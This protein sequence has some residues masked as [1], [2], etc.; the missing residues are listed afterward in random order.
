MIMILSFSE[1]ENCV[2]LVAAAISS[3][4]K[5]E[6]RRF[7]VGPKKEESELEEELVEKVSSF[8]SVSRCICSI[9]FARFSLS[10]FVLI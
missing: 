10:P 6:P 8:D 7:R 2:D 9:S 3:S 5:L 4:V 1:R